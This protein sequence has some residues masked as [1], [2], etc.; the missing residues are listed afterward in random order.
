MDKNIIMTNEG[1]LVSIQYIKKQMQENFLPT[2]YFIIIEK[3]LRVAKT[4]QALPYDLGNAEWIIVVSPYN[5]EYL[6]YTNTSLKVIGIY[7]RYFVNSFVIPFNDWFLVDLE[8]S[9]YFGTYYNAWKPSPVL[10]HRRIKELTSKDYDW[11]KKFGAFDINNMNSM[12]DA[13]WEFVKEQH[14]K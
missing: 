4:Y 8:F 5:W 3:G 13:I 1:F 7:N 2:N 11:S 14:N 10:R 6:G 12:L 9:C